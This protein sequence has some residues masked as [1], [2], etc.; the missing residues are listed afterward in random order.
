MFGR[1]KAHH[2]HAQSTSV[3]TMR[4]SGREHLATRVFVAEGLRTADDSNPV[5]SHVR[6]II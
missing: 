6:C 5:K 4:V 3:K 1:S 2:M